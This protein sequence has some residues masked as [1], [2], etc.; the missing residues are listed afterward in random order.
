LAINNI[1]CFF[2][3][4]ESNF[5][6]P[7]RLRDGSLSSEGRLEVF[8]G[9]VWGTVCDSRFS[10]QDGNV[11]CRQLGFF[12]AKRIYNFA[13]Y[14]MASNNTPIVLNSV[15][16]IGTEAQFGDCFLNLR[17]YTSCSHTDD[18]GVVCTRKV[19]RYY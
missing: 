7:V 13:H 17:R 12:G 18:V 4:L 11:V 9:V 16:C 1:S 10:I 2:V 15:Y 3:C 14:P 5:T 19:T 6:V 8:N